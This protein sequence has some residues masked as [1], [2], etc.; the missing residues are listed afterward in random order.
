MISI[1]LISANIFVLGVIAGVITCTVI[2]KRDTAR[3]RAVERAR[4]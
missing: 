4:G 2:A 3:F 1:I